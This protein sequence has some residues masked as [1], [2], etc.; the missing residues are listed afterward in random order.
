MK[1]ILKNL[2]IRNKFILI[3][4]L[5]TLIATISA[6]TFIIFYQ[7]YSFKEDLKDNTYLNAKLIGEYCV[8][9]LLFH[10]DNGA[11]DILSKIETIPYL[12][13]SIVY[14]TTGEKFAFY[15]KNKQDSDSISIINKQV[16]DTIFFKD[17]NLFVVKSI[18][19]Q[20]IKYGHILL[21]AST[22]T[23]LSK[24]NNQL[25]VMVILLISLIIISYFLANK[26]Q[27]LVSKPI[28]HLSE[29]TQKISDTREYKIRLK[30]SGK[31]EIS[32]LYNGF[33]HMLEQIN[34]RESER[35]EA[36][37]NI[38]KLNLELEQRVEERTLLLKNALL[39]LN[40]TNKSKDMLFSIMGHDLKNSIQIL[41]SAS[42][43]LEIFFET[44]NYE[45][46]KKYIGI[47]NKS[48][49]Q[50]KE[51][52][53]DIL[54]WARSQTDRIWYQPQQ[55]NITE[56]LINCNKLVDDSARSKNI[57]VICEDSIDYFALADKNM[58][59]TV[60][61]N[62][63]FNAIKFTSEGG[64][65]Y[66]ECRSIGN[67][68]EV[69]VKDNGVGMSQADISKLFRIDVST[70]DIGS[71]KQKGSGLGLIICKELIDKH[72]GNIWAE[73]MHGVGSSFKFTLPIYKP[74]E[75]E[76]ESE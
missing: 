76:F 22:D 13:K 63:L 38:Q 50:L 25:L 51:L 48:S 46:I 33:N 74:V 4:L 24:I 42:E 47:I 12:T 75:N 28:T 44:N 57:E 52:L 21:I 5:V 18:V 49:L 26:L 34:I 59:F 61:R 27:Y 41:M 67:N 31:D 11:K 19:Y 17:N 43:S 66:L 9:T 73:S 35:D 32:A 56:I 8:P 16:K 45:K 65:V 68:I 54:V 58:I 70:K 3:I 14:D 10:D 64:K 29:V 37:L 62:L 71:A 55:I 15:S 39:E 2:S 40:N 30:V 20:N 53:D 60:V 36:L 23:L 72:G 1:Q 6:F 7:Y 69:S